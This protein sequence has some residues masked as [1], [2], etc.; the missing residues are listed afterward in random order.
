MPGATIFAKYA[1][2]RVTIGAMTGP[3]TKPDELR[4]ILVTATASQRVLQT[5]VPTYVPSSK[6]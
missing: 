3:G 4:H 6:D 2:V 5:L 1:F